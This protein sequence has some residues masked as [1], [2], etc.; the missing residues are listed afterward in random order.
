VLGDAIVIDISPHKI[1]D[2]RKCDNTMHLSL[3]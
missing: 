3:V 2:L 1:I